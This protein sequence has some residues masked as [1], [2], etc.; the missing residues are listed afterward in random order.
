MILSPL[1]PPHEFLL[2][3]LTTLE[4]FLGEGV[5]ALLPTICPEKELE[6]HV[7]FDPRGP[8][9]RLGRPRAFQCAKK[10]RALRRAGIDWF[11]EQVK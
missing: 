5:L 10:L 11:Q 3:S 9:Q 4:P 2:D 8:F 7:S 1:D 6:S